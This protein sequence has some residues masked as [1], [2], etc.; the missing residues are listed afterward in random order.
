MSLLAQDGRSL[1]GRRRRPS[2]RGGGKERQKDLGRRTAPGRML[3]RLF[4]V[5]DGFFRLAPLTSRKA[6]LAQPIFPDAL[7]DGQFLLVA[8]RRTGGF[9]AINRNCR[10]AGVQGVAHGNGNSDAHG[11]I[12]SEG[13]GKDEHVEGAKSHSVVRQGQTHAGRGRRVGL[14]ETHVVRADLQNTAGKASSVV[15]GTIVRVGAAADAA[16]VVRD[17]QGLRGMPALFVAQRQ[18]RG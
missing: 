16:R 18:G 17:T 13:N 3:A 11:R 7:G 6:F 12:V 14:R 10:H 15:E 5:E 4:N 2:S 8:P 1:G 9:V